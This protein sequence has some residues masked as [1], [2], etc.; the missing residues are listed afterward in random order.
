[1][2]TT[3]K[4]N[5]D[6][7]EVAVLGS[8]LAEPKCLSEVSCI[9]AG[10]HFG[11]SE[12]RAIFEAMR[13]LKA[14]GKP[15]DI[16][17]V[18]SEVEN[19]IKRVG[20]IDYL[21][22][23]TNDVPSALHATHYASLVRESAQL[24]RIIGLSEM[25]IRC[26]GDAVTRKKLVEAI[27]DTGFNGSTSIGMRDAV[28]IYMAELD[29]RVAKSGPIFKTGFKTLDTMCAGGLQ[30]GQLV[31]IG[32]RTSKGKSAI[33]LQ[34]ALAIASRGGRVLFHS[35]EMAIP[36]ILDRA[37]AMRSSLSVGR[38]RL[39]DKKDINDIM[40]TV[41][42]MWTLPI[43]WGDQ[44][45]FGLDGFAADIEKEKPDVLIVDYLQRIPVGPRENRA[46]MFSDVANGL[47]SLALRTK[48]AIITASQL[49]RNIEFRDD[50]TPTL[51]D[52]K[53]SGGIEEASDIVVL[54]HTPEEDQTT[55]M[56]TGSL[57]VA[58]NRNGAVSSI[59]IRF[60]MAKTRFVEEN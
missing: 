51:A 5:I 55:G 57:I 3:A 34:M 31:T 38:V 8:I 11:S 26:P 15:V 9:I 36:E 33:L 60:E 50:Q 4:A 21:F 6:I 29:R 48:T 19:D 42:G 32:A 43:R 7:N 47:K 49:S 13:R 22:K 23:L 16:V 10:E 17:T 1:M 2:T 54:V 39:S 45:V 37:V 35:Q 18:F 14:D 44:K 56:R 46:A 27:L 25:I 30:P 24:R 59:P 28:T 12:H 52:L 58:K 20:G 41:T 53:E 40:N